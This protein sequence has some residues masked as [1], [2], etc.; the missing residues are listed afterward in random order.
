MQHKKT[1]AGFLDKDS[2]G[3]SQRKYFFI[4]NES[5]AAK[6]CCHTPI[7]KADVCCLQYSKN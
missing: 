4:F 6:E 3:L 7:T 1:Y 5:V 2:S